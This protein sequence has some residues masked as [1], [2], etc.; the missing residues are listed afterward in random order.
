MPRS[1]RLV[2]P[3]FPHHVVHRG[4]NRGAILFDDADK[5]RFLASLRA[6][7]ERHE[8]TIQAYV[9]MGNHVHLLLTPEHE[10]GLKECMRRLAQLH[11]QHINLRHGRSGG[12]WEG[13]FKSFI[14]ECDRYL[15]AVQRYIELNPV[16]AGLATSATTYP[17]SS[18]RGNAGLARDDLLTPHPLMAEAFGHD[19][20]ADQ[21]YADWLAKGIPERE[22]SAIR[23]YSAQERALGSRRFQEMVSRALGRPVI[24]R[25]PGQPRKGDGVGGN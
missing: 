24:P 10:T 23:M 25:P 9:L 20:T 12:L 4:I 21:R 6:T 1:P 7:V 22:L 5:H 2:L 18:A 11:A 14:V 15:F 8:V 3:G 17:W 19:G 13:R 16:R